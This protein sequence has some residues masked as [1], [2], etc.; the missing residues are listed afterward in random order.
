MRQ[1]VQKISLMNLTV[2]HS[3]F[4]SA[5]LMSMKMEVKHEDDGY[6]SEV[7]FSDEEA[8]RMSGPVNIKNC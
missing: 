8:F 1:A 6:S 3:D 5:A 2:S 7:V 4:E